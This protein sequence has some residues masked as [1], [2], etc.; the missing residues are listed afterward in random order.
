MHLKYLDLHSEMNFLAMIPPKAMIPNDSDKANKWEQH[1][2]INL[3]HI[4]H[5]T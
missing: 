3:I 4:F 1:A 2:L 5:F